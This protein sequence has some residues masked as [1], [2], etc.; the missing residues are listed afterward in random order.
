MAS[1]NYHGRRF[2]PL[3]N[4]SNGQATD[5]TEFVYYQDGGLLT[6]TY[7]GGG[8]RHGQIVGTVNADGSLEFLYQHLTDDGELRSGLCVSHPEI[9]PDGRVRLHEDWR[10]TSG[11]QSP[12]QSIVEEAPD[13]WIQ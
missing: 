8:I 7:G 2:R 5:K 11:D 13:A 3:S 4:S 6:G 10:W 12:G 1:I 9:L